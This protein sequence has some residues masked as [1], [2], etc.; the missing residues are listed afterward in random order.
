MFIVPTVIHF[1]APCF[2][3]FSM[4]LHFILSFYFFFLSRLESLKEVHRARQAE[5]RRM[6]GDAE[7][8]KNS[9]EILEESSSES[10]LKFYRAMTLYVHNLVECLRE[11]V[12]DEW[13][14]S[15]LSSLLTINKHVRK[16]SEANRKFCGW[17]YLFPLTWYLCIYQTTMCNSEKWCVANNEA[18]GF[19]SQFWWNGRH[20][21]IINNVWFFRNILETI[22]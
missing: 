14:L 18:T 2:V 12:R 13:S 4:C 11:K 1:P 10:Q 8:A 21:L 3:I 15:K 20:I 6:E 5:Q 17:E 16:T 9:V 19:G 22:I 7:N